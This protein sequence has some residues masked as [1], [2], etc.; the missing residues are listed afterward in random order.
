MLLGWKACGLQTRFIAITSLCVVL[1]AVCV[2]TLVGW[3]ERSRVESDLRAFSD[4]ELK[5]LH[6]LVLSA[7]AER[8]G[9]KQGVA[10][11]VYNRWFESR[12]SD[13]PGKLWSV[14][15]PKL[16]AYMATREPDRAPKSPHD[17][18]DEEA[19]SSGQPVARLVGDTY[20]YS[21]PIV[22]GV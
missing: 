18:V 22:M 20:R 12:N 17:A 14:W 3:Y 5:S 6:A 4:N 19:L 1:L 8:R 2:V 16:T 9:D 13:Y 11:A 10:I 7:M 15:S 21:L